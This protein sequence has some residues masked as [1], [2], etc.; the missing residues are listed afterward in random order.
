MPRWDPDEVRLFQEATR[1]RLQDAAL[2]LFSELGYSETTAAAIAEHAGLTQRTFFRYF[3]DKREVLFGGEAL[4]GQML[5]E[6]LAA[7]SS[8]D[9]VAVA[10]VGLQAIAAALEPHRQLQQ[11][12]TRIIVANPELQEKE[13]TKLNAWSLTIASELEGRGVADSTAAIIAEASMAVFRLAFKRWALEESVTDLTGLV[14]QGLGELG[15]FAVL[16]QEEANDY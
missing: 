2:E 13:L 9:P 7:A 10:Q 1:R 14:N 3:P 15:L 6:A 16:A 11:I 8:A 12:R 4:L 5:A